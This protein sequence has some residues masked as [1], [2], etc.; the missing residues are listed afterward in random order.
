MFK[1]L[2]KGTYICDTKEDLKS[3]AETELGSECYVI[4]D[5]VTYRLMS[6]GEWVAPA[7]AVANGGAE[8]DLTGYATETFVT[9]AAEEAV[10]TSKKYT[11]DKIGKIKIPSTTNFVK[12]ED[13]VGYA[14]DVELNLVKA[15]PVLKFFNMDRNPAQHDAQAI[16]LTAAENIDLAKAMTEKGLGIYNI[17]IEKGHS[18]LP[19]TMIKDNTSGRGFAVVDFQQNSDTIGYVVLF[20]KQNTMYYRF[21]SHNIFGPWMKV[22]AEQA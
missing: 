15:N 12:K 22:A 16:Y 14:T 20:D 2:G 7:K 4:K 3:I 17:W 6:T 8:V 21:L 11:D 9:N 10:T 1:R 5:G 13:L 19:Q 18:S